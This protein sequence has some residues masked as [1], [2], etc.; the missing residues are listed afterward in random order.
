MKRRHVLASVGGAAI[1]GLA[2]CVGGVADG[3]TGDAAAEAGLPLTVE[4][5]SAPGSTAGE[6]RLPVPGTPTLLDLFATW[7]VPCEAQMEGLRTVHR[8]FG[9]AVAFVSVT[10]ERFGGGLTAA[11][12]RDWWRENGGDWTV[13]HDPEGDLFAALRAGGLPYLVL[14]DADGSVVW[15]HQGVA[16]AARLREELGDVA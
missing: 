13:G 2:G 9:G 8:E 12:V 10:N 6:Q 16:A 3:G 1:A 7:C 15:R 14:V 4:T 5:L 11:D